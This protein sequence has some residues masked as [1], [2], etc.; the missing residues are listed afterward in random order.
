MQSTF[1]RPTGDI[2][3]LLDLASRDRQ[4]ND[5]FP[6]GTEETWFTR[7]PDRRMLPVTPL[8]ADFPFRGPASFG[9]TF[10]FDI[11]SVPCGDVV[12]GC[13]VQ[14]RLSHWL[15]KTTQLHIQSGRYTYV[16]PN[17][18]WFYAN[19]LGTSIIE[20]AELEIDGKTIETIDGD[21]INTF[22][23]LFTDLNTQI[24]I[25]VD[26]LGRVSI[27]KLLA[28]PPSRLFPTEDGVLHC[29]LPFFFM[30]N[31]LQDALPMIAVREG[32]ARIHITLRPFSDCVRQRRGYRDTCTSVPLERT[33]EF[34]DTTFP[35]EQIVPIQTTNAIP[36]FETIRLLTFGAV[37]NGQIRETMLRKP[38]EVLHR[39]VQTFYFT[40][41]LKY[42]VSKNNSADSVR[43]QLPLEANHPLEEIVWFIRRK[44]VNMNNEWTNYSSVLERGY[45]LTF[46]PPGP[47][48]VSA[49]I[50]V[51]GVTICEAEE[52]Y[53]R[54]LIARHHRGGIVPYTRFIYGYP[55]ARHP[56]EHQP[57]GTLNASRVQ[58][59]RLTLEVKGGVGVEW[60]V[61]VFCIGLNWLRFQN[62]IANAVFDT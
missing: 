3:T 42:T 55:F 60:E 6:Q 30:R 53:Y 22:S 19:S 39:E 13:A 26:H 8:I 54:D 45:D 15:D 62:G 47:M 10:T 56:A 36:D 4:D 31:R 14:I 58:N 27:P 40:E 17:E 1:K 57:S 61:K 38:F 29:V 7:D 32:T 37:V 44:D 25:S 28:W 21:F 48:L 18:A 11:G 52:E 24:G 16:N 5:F 35:Y 41:P 49:A 50:Q 46:S 23:S 2:T 20:K 12:F 43:I 51:N 33:F 34:Y 9:Q 59:L